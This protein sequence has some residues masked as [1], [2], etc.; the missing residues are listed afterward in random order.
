MKQ[1]FIVIAILLLLVQVNSFAQ[2][3]PKTSL[4]MALPLVVEEG[5]FSLVVSDNIDVVLIPES[6]DNVKVKA[7][8]AVI[9]KLKVSYSEGR[10]FLDAAKNVGKDERLV[11]YVWINDLEN[12]TLKGNSYAISQGILQS[13]DLHISLAKDASVL[14]KSKGNVWFD[15]PTNHQVLKEKGYFMVTS[16]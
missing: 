8:D 15:A 9:S 13:K 7:T 12:L 11:V 3:E 5:I 1:K 4:A 6:P 2:K 14:L 16:L 10:L